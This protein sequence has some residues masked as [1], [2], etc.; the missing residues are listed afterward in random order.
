[1]ITLDDKAFNFIKRLKLAEFF[2]NLTEQDSV[3]NFLSFIGNYKKRPKGRVTIYAPPPIFSEIESLLRNYVEIRVL[4]AESIL[5]KLQDY[6]KLQSGIEVTIN[7]DAKILEFPKILHIFLENLDEITKNRAICSFLQKFSALSLETIILLIVLSYL[8]RK[9]SLDVDNRILEFL[10]GHIDTDATFLGLS[11]LLSESRFKSDTEVMKEILILVSRN[12]GIDLGDISIENLSH[13][14]PLM[15]L[16]SLTGLSEEI[17]QTLEVSKSLARDLE[18]RFDEKEK[19]SKL[20]KLVKSIDKCSNITKVLILSLLPL[21]ITESFKYLFKRKIIP[22]LSTTYYLY[23]F[24]LLLEAVSHNHIELV[25][26]IWEEIIKEKG[27]SLLRK[28]IDDERLIKNLLFLT[29]KHPEIKKKIEY[30]LI[31]SDPELL[32]PGINSVKQMNFENITLRRNFMTL[33]LI[34]HK[35]ISFKDI[36]YSF[37]EVIND[38]SSHWNRDRSLES[39]HKIFSVIEKRL[40]P[41]YSRLIRELDSIVFREY[42]DGKKIAPWNLLK[43]L[44]DTRPSIV[45]KRNLVIIID[46]L[47]VDFLHFIERL[48]LRKGFYTDFYQSFLT[49]IPSITHVCRSFIFGVENSSNAREIKRKLVEVFSNTPK[50]HVVTYPFSSRQP[51]NQ[52]IEANKVSSEKPFVLIILFNFLDKIIHQSILR[53]EAFKL[54]KQLFEKF[55]REIIDKV[56]P[57]TII[58]IGEHG[59]LTFSGGIIESAPPRIVCQYISSRCCFIRE[60]ELRSSDQTG[61]LY[62]SSCSSSEQPPHHTRVRL[63]L[64]RKVL[65][66]YVAVGSFSF[67]KETQGYTNSHGGISIFENIMPILVYKPFKYEKVFSSLL[68]V[69]VKE[70]KK[71]DQEIHAREPMLEIIMTNLSDHLLD[72]IKVLVRDKWGIFNLIYEIPYFLPRSEEKIILPLSIIKSLVGYELEEIEIKVQVTSSYYDETLV[73]V[74]KSIN[75]RDISPFTLLSYDNLFSEKLLSISGE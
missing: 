10:S 38:N 75:L 51:L 72:K 27:I 50:I 59:F 9:L 67:L 3:K 23:K 35:L 19:K 63:R 46:A 65:E 69:E 55:I 40:I 57:D 48:F 30:L 31:E 66:Y 74:S 20:I 39:V 41:L 52:I 71:R 42:C 29:E 58:I 44:I 28:H 2:F 36:K 54:F 21:K 34:L 22:R 16:F 11:V 60:E 13:I 15:S 1:M 53:K 70:I 73:R 37:T 7:I 5:N 17:V 26:K 6:I 8:I 45:G 24:M 14:L 43:W 4:N 61:I 32:L 47:S 62:I 25:H 49:P 64:G 18:S 68:K 56:R 12:L 33:S